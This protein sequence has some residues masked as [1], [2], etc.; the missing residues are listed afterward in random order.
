MPGLPF[1]IPDPF[2]NPLPGPFRPGEWQR[3]PVKFEVPVWQRLRWPA[4]QVRIL[5]VTDG[6]SYDET[7]GF[8][9]GI[10]LKDAFD[11]THPEHP[12]YA[13]FTF[14]RA[15]HAEAGG[16]DFGAD[17]GWAGI[18]LT[19][20]KLAGFDQLWLFGVSSSAPYL[21]PNEVSAIEAFMD[22]GGG[23]L[24]MGDHEA[25]GLGLCGKIKRVR[26]MRKWW[27]T[28]PPPPAGMLK[29]PDSTDL[30]RN[31]TVHA[32]SPGGDVNLG[33]QDDATPQNIYPSWRLAHHLWRPYRLLKYPHP[34]LCGPRGAIVVM[35]DHQHE[36]DCVMPDAAFASEYAGG[37]AVEVVARGRNVVGRTK[38]GY[39][40]VDAREFGLIGAW[41]GHDPRAGKGRVLVDSTWH[42]W[43]NVNLF[44]LR[45]ENGDE[46]KDVLAYYRNVAV[47]LSPLGQQAAMRRAGT[48]IF[49]LSKTMVEHTLTLREF[50]S[51]RLYQIGVDARDALGRVAPQ[52]QSAGWFLHWLEPV[53]S[54]AVFTRAAARAKGEAIDPIEAAGMDVLTTTILGGAVNALAMALHK[55]GWSKLDSL[56]D[57]LDAAMAEGAKQGLEVATKQL[58]LGQRRLKALAA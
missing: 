17:A 23:V 54:K 28:S 2:G 48:L 37:V 46:Y 14:V 26:S 3:P 16:F 33:Q 22:G 53:L 8:G 45:A 49:M 34:V 11:P 44:G 29:A 55:R 15:T 21:L 1:D 19:A 41:D 36:G 39:T 6:A 10:A 58:A 25:M 20:D 43:F 5:V 51:D 4:A 24:A 31:D 50:R 13:R 32:I 52:C 40:V 18:R 27:Y 30:T 57:E 38:G 7:S 35:P 56:G 12:A 42:H 47:W 9:L